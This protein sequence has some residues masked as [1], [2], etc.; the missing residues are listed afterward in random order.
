MPFYGKD[1]K[2]LRKAIKEKDPDFSS[3]KWSQV[4]PKA[5]NFVKLG[6]QKDPAKRPSSYQMLEHAWLKESKCSHATKTARK[7]NSKVPAGP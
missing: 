2:E 7:T 3:Y 5:K 1:L 4:C 6:L